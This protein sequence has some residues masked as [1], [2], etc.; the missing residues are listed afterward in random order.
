[1]KS[2]QSKP[3]NPQKALR[4]IAAIMNLQGSLA[5]RKAVALGAAKSAGIKQ[6]V[7]AGM[8]DTLT[9]KEVAP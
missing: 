4:E 2:A 1:M 3:G 7:A 6:A 5:V 8:V 9:A